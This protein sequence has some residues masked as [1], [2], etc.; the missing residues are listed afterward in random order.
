MKITQLHLYKVRPRWV[1]LEI[2]TN[3][4]LSGWGEP[5]LEGRADTV[6]AAVRELEPL[7]VGQDPTQINDL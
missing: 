4:G 1:F 6:R 3:E 7:L 2:E 5:V